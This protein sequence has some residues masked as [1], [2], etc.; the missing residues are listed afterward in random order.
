MFMILIFFLSNMV[1]Q[2]LLKNK[3]NMLKVRNIEKNALANGN[4]SNFLMEI[5]I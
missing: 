2:K 5:L 1:K 4:M 3:R